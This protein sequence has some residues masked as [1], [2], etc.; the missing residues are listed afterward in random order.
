MKTSCFSAADILLPDFSKTDGTKWAVIACDQYTS[1]PHYWEG[2]AD[3]V[4]D[5]PS[6][7]SLILPELYLSDR[8]AERVAEI[9]A[10]MDKAL[11]TVLCEHKNSMIY[12]RRT[13]QNGTVRSGLVG[14]LD[15]TAYSFLPEDKAL[16]RATEGTVISRIPPR[17]EVRRGAPI[18]LPHVMLLTDDPQDELLAPLAANR[19]QYALAYRF[20]LQAGGG[21]VEGWF[22]PAS[23]IERVNR[24]LLERE[25][26]GGETPFLFAVGDGNHS[27]A[28][29][30][31]HYEEIAKNL[32]PEEAA[33]HPA[34]Y[35]L[36]ELVNIHDASLHFEPIYRV[37]F[38]ADKTLLSE[39]AAYAEACKQDKACEAN[40][41]QTIHYVTK[42]FEG[43]V[44]FEKGAHSLTVGSLQ[45]FL[46]TYCK[47]HPEVEIDYIHG[48]D[49][50]R[51][52]A[53]NE[54]AIGFL[55]D[56]MQ[57]DELFSS[58]AKDGPLPR[59]TFSMGEAYDKRY[60][61]EARRIR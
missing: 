10:Q 54:G 11:E 51:A 60:Y 6:T 16:V 17:V 58:V 39:L 18:E 7:L 32:T 33:V 15:L 14:K 21:S 59:K 20:P 27:L 19:E 23:E 9:N 12:L 42:D 46:D 2:V 37:A 1:E 61:L 26:A 24:V 52:L 55:F 41:K 29:A 28:S 22:L 30:K 13:C 3:Y 50:L 56:G 5:A 43:D 44:V 57:K 35:A 38:H 49:S 34:R 53:K 36:I 48:E 47:T 31:A 40:G 25:A 45:I 8:R 4:G